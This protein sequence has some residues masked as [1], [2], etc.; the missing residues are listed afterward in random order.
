MA[1]GQTLAIRL[2]EGLRAFACTE[3]QV[4]R[5]PVQKTP[6]GVRVG[7]RF[8]TRRN[9][10]LETSTPCRTSWCRLR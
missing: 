1:T 5:A 10:L 8:E 7:I 6:P 2:A 4:E 3:L 9:E